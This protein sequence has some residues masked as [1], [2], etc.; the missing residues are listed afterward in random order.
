MEGVP[1]IGKGQNFNTVVLKKA[2]AE[3]HSA[4]IEFAT[5]LQ[6]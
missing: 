6:N 4:R 5:N 2:V 3:I 1:A